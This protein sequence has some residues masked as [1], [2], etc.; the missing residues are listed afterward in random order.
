MIYR[1]YEN[2][3]AAWVRRVLF[4]STDEQKAAKKVRLWPRTAWRVIPNGVESVD[5]DYRVSRRASL[6]RSLGL[7]D[8]QPIVAT[9]SRFD[10]AKNMP[11]CL[12]IARRQPDVVFL[13]VGDGEDAP[14]LRNRMYSEQLTN[15]RMLGAVD[16]PGPVLAA[17]DVYLATSRWEG[18]PLS[19]LEAMAVGIP[20]VASDVTGHRELL[21]ESAAGFL[22]PLGHPEIAGTLL[23]RLLSDAA[24]RTRLG[25]Q[26]RLLQRERYSA[27]RMA[28]AVY[29]IYTDTVA[30]PVVGR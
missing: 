5:E 14:A 24:L 27:G 12:E 20:V 18:L 10:F 1:A 2:R 28:R 30:S 22:Y 25:Q 17:S 16:D 21:G 9:I 6:R 4:V 15:V 13:W 7:T 8:R 26:G 11:E 29:E 3:S 23:Q 19:V